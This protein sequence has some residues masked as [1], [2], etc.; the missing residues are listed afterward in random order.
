MSKDRQIP[1]WLARRAY[2]KRIGRWTRSGK[3]GTAA[4]VTT[5]ATQPASN[6][7]PFP[8]RVDRSDRPAFADRRSI[9]RA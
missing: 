6:V 9:G 7:V 8:I 2:F 3:A 5:E 4:P 1:A